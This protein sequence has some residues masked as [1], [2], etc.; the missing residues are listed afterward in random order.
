LPRLPPGRHGLP[1]DFVER[2]QRDR[3]TA[4]IISAVAEHGYNDSTITQIVEAAGLSRRTFY[5][6]FSSKEEC[7]L[8]TWDLIA[9][10]LRAAATEAAAVV[11]DWPDKVRARLGAV[12]GVYAENPDLARFMLIVPVRAGDAVA[13]RYRLEMARVLADISDGM[14]QGKDT[15]SEA[16]G[17][18]IVG[19]VVSL[20]ARNVEAGEGDDLLSLLPDLLE[21]VLAPYVGREEA[22]QLA[23]GAS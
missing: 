8:A 14:P 18:A 10:H 5:T 16:V 21:L 23:R 13:D 1:R 4:G 15:P 2:N 19:G 3:L 17:Q 12:L 20:I 22:V 11:D 6:Y 7:Y 9:D